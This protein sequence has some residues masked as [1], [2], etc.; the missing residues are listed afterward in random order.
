MHCSQP[1]PSHARGAGAAAGMSAAAMGGA[2]GA[3]TAAPPRRASSSTGSTGS[4]S[5][6]Y[7]P[8]RAPAPPPAPEH[9]HDLGFAPPAANGEPLYQAVSPLKLALMSLC[10]A[11]IY[12]LYIFYKHWQIVKART[13]ANISPFWRTFFAPFHAFDL[14]KRIRSD[15]ED[16]GVLVNWNPNSLAWA[17]FALTITWRLPDPYWLIT[18]LS[19]IP[20][21]S[22]Q[23]TVQQLNAAVAPRADR[24]ESFTPSNIMGLLIGGLFMAAVLVGTFV[25]LK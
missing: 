20:V 2:G 25:E 9:D 14:F 12:E 10:T 19:F 11:G 23:A 13:G 17:F 15:A 18:Y 16:A 21:M 8:P 24:N 4:T 1:I 22:V 7:R 6:S 5:S 3:A